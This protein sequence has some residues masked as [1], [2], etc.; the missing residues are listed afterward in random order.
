MRILLVTDSTPPFVSG[1]VRTFVTT[2]EHLRN[3]G[4]EVRVVSPSDFWTIPCPFYPQ[5]P[6]AVAVGGK[7]S[8][9]IEEF[10]PD[11]I[12]LAAEGPLGMA[13]RSWC[14]RNDVPFTTS[15]T[16]KYPEYLNAWY[17]VPLSF[18]YRLLRWFHDPAAAVMVST[19]SF[20]RELHS[21]GFNN[22]VSW[23]RGVDLELFCPRDKGFLEEARP[24]SL[25]VGRVTKEK[26]L[27]EF[28]DL[29]I[30]GTKYVVGTGPRLNAWRRKYPD[31]HFAGV[32]RGEQL[33]SYYAAADVLVFPSRT[34][35]FG[36]VMLESLACGVPVA[37]Y[38]VTGPRDVIGDSTVGVLNDDLSKA[39]EEALLI[40]P[41]SC[42]QFAERFR[43]EH[44]VNQFLDNLR[45]VESTVPDMA[46]VALRRAA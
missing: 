11:A 27:A 14:L 25:Y 15:F 1:F 8:R 10:Q 12:H 6:L 9:M 44:S 26:N 34:D 30:E 45:P 37:A 13:A 32:Q 18:T 20:A 38:P 7:V 42:R 28:L 43:W 40:D 19:D 35:T 39:V 2:I 33:A 36:L 17:G 46:E 21:W 23:T 5:L 3:L 41:N 16:T 4:H 31:V 24:I 22:L 29:T